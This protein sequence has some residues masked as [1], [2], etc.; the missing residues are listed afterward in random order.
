MN[1]A[2]HAKEFPT[3]PRPPLPDERSQRP[4]RIS[5][6]TETY[7][8]Q[9]NGVSRTLDRLVRYLTAQG[10]E[11]QVLAPRYRE[12]TALPIGAQLTVFPGFPLP[13][14]PEISVCLATPGRLRETLRR[15]DP[16]VVHAPPRAPWASAPS[17]PPEP[18]ACRS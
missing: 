10:H 11:V 1:L 9:V 2:R 12:P 16:D 15:F 18:R 4:L 14:Y 5:L 13:F 6:V 8:P 3:P 17:R 7:F